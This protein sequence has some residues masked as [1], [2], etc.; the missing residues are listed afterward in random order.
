[1]LGERGKR[2][3]SKHTIYKSLGCRRAQY[4]TTSDC[5]ENRLQKAFSW[6]ESMTLSLH[7]NTKQPHLLWAHRDEGSQPKILM[8]ARKRGQGW[9]QPLAATP[10]Q[11]RRGKHGLSFHKDLISMRSKQTN[12]SFPPPL[13]KNITSCAGGQD[14]IDKE[15]VSFR[16]Y[17]CLMKYMS[18]ETAGLEAGAA[19]CLCLKVFPG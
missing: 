2:I 19:L 7:S 6:M 15:R 4:A 11:T 1:M 18:K 9:E 12:P 5:F 14:V 10:L 16:N 17:N 8:V 3:R 13:W